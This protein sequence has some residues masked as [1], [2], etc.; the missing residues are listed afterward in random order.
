MPGSS[1]WR[2]Y[3]ERGT[4]PLDRFKM[5]Q[6]H[7][8]RLI[9]G[10]FKAHRRPKAFC[11]QRCAFVAVVVLASAFLHACAGLVPQGKA[12]P[13]GRPTQSE[14]FLE[15]LDDAVTGAGV[16]EASSHSVPGFP[17]LRT[18]RFL[19]AIK[20]RLVDE[21]DKR[22]WVAEMARLDSAARQKE[23]RNLP[24]EAVRGLSPAG[25]PLFDREALLAET[26]S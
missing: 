4:L 6:R 21:E 13:A 12:P 20:I 8:P 24:D 7:T 18:D 23:I 11:R 1:G 19:A 16:R 26:S 9:P 17:Y 3:P 25:G 14:K 2:D 22:L 5:R 10:P 15:A